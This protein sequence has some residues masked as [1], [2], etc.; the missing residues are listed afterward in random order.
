MLKQH[1]KLRTFSK[2]AKINIEETKQTD[3]QTDETIGQLDKYI[4]RVHLFV[5]LMW[6][7]LFRA[8]VILYLHQQLLHVS[9]GW[10]RQILL[11]KSCLSY[12][13]I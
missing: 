11:R 10:Y 2:T 8:P 6:S 13:L 12:K 5:S 4:C 9:S 3:E 1:R 7:E